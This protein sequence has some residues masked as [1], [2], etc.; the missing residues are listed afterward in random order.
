MDRTGVLARGALHG[1]RIS[2]MGG[3]IIAYYPIH[4]DLVV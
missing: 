4:L 3:A 1:L 2:N